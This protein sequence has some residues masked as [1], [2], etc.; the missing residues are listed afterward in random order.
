[1]SQI[2]IVGVEIQWRNYACAK[3]YGLDFT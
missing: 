3:K 2:C 1:M